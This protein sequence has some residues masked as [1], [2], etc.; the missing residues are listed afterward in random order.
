MKWQKRIEK[1]NYLPEKGYVMEIVK[2]NSEDVST[3]CEIENMIFS[4]PWSMK[5][6]LDSIHDNKNLYLVA[7]DGDEIVAYCGLWGIMDEGHITNVAVKENYRGKG[8]GK[9]MLN[10]LLELGKEKGLVAF[11][12]E[13]RIGNV[14]AINLYKNL[15][16]IDAG[17][18]KN[19]YEDPVEDGLIMWLYC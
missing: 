8:I 14:A 13:V 18:R 7:K 3:V 19:F 12:L 5:S 1:N 10:K 16:F 4:K 9:K 6:F 2:M 11:T 15:G 17:V